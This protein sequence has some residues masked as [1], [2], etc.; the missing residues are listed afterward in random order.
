MKL[1]DNT[2]NVLKN[3]ATINQGLVIRPGNILRTISGNR[4]ILAEANVE[5]N[6]PLE[7]GIY[8]LNKL[9]SI[10]SHNKG[11]VDLEFEP[12][13][14]VCRSVGSIRMRSSPVGLIVSPPNKRINIDSYD[15]K[16]ELTSEIMNWIFNTAAV[17]KSPHIVLKSDGGDI[18]VWAMD[19][20]GKIVD[21]ASVKVNGTSDV[22][23]QTVF[24]LENLKL[25]G[26]SYTVEVSSAGVAK[27]THNE[28]KVTYWIAVEKKDSKF[29]K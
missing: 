25:L 14:L 17:L 27:F 28:G 4:N 18:N 9:L 22:A 16:F 19:V 7:F 5:E 20:S 24:L 21:D 12:E 3:F 26:G 23:F 11:G 6:F 29:D 13:S 8:D 2:L 1:T 10:V 15:V